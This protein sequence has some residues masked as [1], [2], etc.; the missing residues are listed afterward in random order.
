M[1]WKKN[2]LLLRTISGAVYVAIIIAALMDSERLP[3]VVFGLFLGL[4]A[5]EVLRQVYQQ[6]PRAY[7]EGALMFL[8]FNSTRNTGVFENISGQQYIVPYI[9]LLCLLMVLLFGFLYFK[10]PVRRQM[11]AFG[12]MVY[13]FA[14]MY[15]LL[16]TGFEPYLPESFDGKRV[17]FIFIL[18]WSSDTFAYLSGRTFGK[19]ALAPQISPN[20]TIEGLLG[21]SF[22]TLLISI[23]GIWFFPDAA[24]WQ[25]L[26]LALIT[27]AA[28]TLGDLIQ[29]KWKREYGI[30][31]SGNLLPGHGGFFDRLDSAFLAG[32]AVYVF[33]YLSAL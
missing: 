2:N 13:L 20:K 14:G 4:S 9:I 7:V 18:I 19:R 32:P 29:S 28:S 33:L 3:W 23:T 26:I 25:L 5:Q 30:K 15:F 6:S 24:W 1:S 16:Q 8:L 27:V 17:L 12:M 22:C 21:G 11:E 10:T 31:D